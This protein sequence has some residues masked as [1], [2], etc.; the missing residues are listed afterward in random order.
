[1]LKLSTES[2]RAGTLPVMLAWGTDFAEVITERHGIVGFSRVI[3]RAA[4]SE[5]GL[6]AEEKSAHVLRLGSE[7][8]CKPHPICA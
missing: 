8:T 4:K 6:R 7:E 5:K 1:M 3:L 2:K